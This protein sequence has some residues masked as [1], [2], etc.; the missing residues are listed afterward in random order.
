MEEV[1]KLI[2]DITLKL[3]L[4]NSMR[5]DARRIAS[6]M[7][8]SGIVS[9][10]NP[11][12]VAL[13]SIIIACRLNNIGLGLKQVSTLIPG[14]PR[15]RLDSKKVAK[16]AYELS[17]RYFEVFRPQVGVARYEDYVRIASKLLGLQGEFIGLAED[18]ARSFGSRYG[19]RIKPMAVAGAAIYVALR[20]TGGP[21][22]TM[23]H[24]CSKLN[25]TE[26]TLRNAI[27][28]MRA[29]A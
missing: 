28:L 23:S 6:T 16:K 4:P 20:K 8:E 24:I 29:I 2:D 3:E 26:P 12:I 27:R 11:I 14:L 18:L 21:R 10:V 9:R 7:V 15:G 5:E 1:F 22:L 25:I 13:S 17:R 19:R